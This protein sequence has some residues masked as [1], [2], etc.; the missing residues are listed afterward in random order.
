MGGGIEGHEVMPEGVRPTLAPALL[1][2]GGQWVLYPSSLPL[3]QA[4]PPHPSPKCVHYWER[5]QQTRWLVNTPPRAHGF[6]H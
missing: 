6:L 1:A 4:C 5:G 3:P 2:A